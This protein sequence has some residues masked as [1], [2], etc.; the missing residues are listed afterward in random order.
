MGEQAYKAFFVIMMALKLRKL[1]FNILLN[2][3]VAKTHP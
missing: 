3:L 2:E 1:W